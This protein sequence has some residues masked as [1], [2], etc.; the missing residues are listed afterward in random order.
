MLAKNYYILN[1]WKVEDVSFHQSITTWQMKPC[2]EVTRSVGTEDDAVS[3]K[4]DDDVQKTIRFVSF[5]YQK[6]ICKERQSFFY[7]QHF[8]IFQ[9]KLIRWTVY[10]LFL[11]SHHSHISFLPGSPL[12]PLI[13]GKPGWKKQ[14][15]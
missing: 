13:P 14:I 7:A 9:K 2:S 3:Q 8:I 6:F 12:G 11:A 15:Q 10:K 5:F 4:W 1:M